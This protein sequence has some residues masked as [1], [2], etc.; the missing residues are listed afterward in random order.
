MSSTSTHRIRSARASLPS[1][2]LA[3]L[4]IALG[5]TAM[6]STMVGIAAY[7][8]QGGAATISPAQLQAAEKAA[9]EQGHDAGYKQG[10]TK[11]REVGR[12]AGA[13]AGERKGYGEGVRKGLQKGYKRG[14]QA[15]YDEGYAAGVA[16]AT[17]AQPNRKKKNGGA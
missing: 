5:F 15:G 11:G 9:F 4:L 16:A 2:S 7:S 13:L 3:A 10:V 1:F 14:H 17:P 6:V 8:I 12:K